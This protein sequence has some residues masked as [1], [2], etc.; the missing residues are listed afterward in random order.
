MFEVRIQ[1]EAFD[2]GAESRRLRAGRTDIGALVV[3]EGICRDHAPGIEGVQS[4]ELEHYPEMTAASIER[5]VEQ[6]R[7]RWPLQGAVVVHRVGLLH[8][9]DPIVLVAVASSHRHDA[10]EACAFLMDYLKTQAPLWKK[11]ATAQGAQWVDARESDD[12]ALT[13]WGIESGNSRA[14]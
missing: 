10:F 3:F 13:R 6:A 8:P 4:L 12:Q 9:G 11:E 14:S 1:T 2:A 5:M 7:A